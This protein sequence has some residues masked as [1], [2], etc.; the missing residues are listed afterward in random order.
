[1][2]VVSILQ[3]ITVMWKKHDYYSNSVTKIKQ[4]HKEQTPVWLKIFYLSVFF[5]KSLKLKCSL[6]TYDCSWDTVHTWII[7]D[8]YFTS[9]QQAGS[10][11]LCT[12]F[13]FPHDKA[14]G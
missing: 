9:D 14:V 10:H 11:K 5:P 1:M 13:E 3:K 2:Q 12:Q 7:S 4:T 8:V 6:F